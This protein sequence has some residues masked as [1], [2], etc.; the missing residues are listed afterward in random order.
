MTQSPKS[1]S[2]LHSQARDPIILCCYRNS[3]NHMVIVRARGHASYF[4][5]RVVFPFELMS[6]HC[7]R[8]CEIEVISRTPGGFEQSEWVIASELMAGEAPLNENTGWRPNPILHHV[9]VRS[10][11]GSVRMTYH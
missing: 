7:P 2:D 11:E 5:E 3:T 8:D 1:P 6:F 10:S 4:L 9:S